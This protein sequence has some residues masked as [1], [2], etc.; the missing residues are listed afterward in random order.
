[1]SISLCMINPSANGWIEKFFKD[2]SGSFY[3]P[4]DTLGL[5][6]AIRKTGFLYG[7]PKTIATV[8]VFDKVGLS[9]DEVSKIAFLNTLYVTFKLV[10][11]S[12]SKDT[13]V[14]EAIAYYKL[15]TKQNKWSLDFLNIKG[16]ASNQLEEIINSR[17]QI[18]S[19]FFNKTYTFLFNNALLFIDILG[20]YTYLCKGEISI[21]YLKKL[22][23][24]CMAL[25]ML[26]VKNKEN[27]KDYEVVLLKMIESSLRYSKFNKKSEFTIETLDFSFFENDIERYYFYDLI[28]MALWKEDATLGDRE[29]YFLEDVK[30][31]LNLPASF[32]NI[33]SGNVNDFIQENKSDLSIFNYSNPLIQFYENSNKTVSKLIKRNGKRLTKEIKQSKE[34]MLLL[35][36]STTK[37]LNKEEKKKVK[38]QLLDI[39]KSVPSLAIF[40]LP[41]GS[42]LLPILIKYIPK[43]LPSAFNENLED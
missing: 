22:E 6:I 21:E 7:H 35:A 9:E 28:L 42:L 36:K 8:L 18:N 26:S 12:N 14:A 3:S 32:Y 23:Y 17:V 40:L 43:L 10:K 39:C 20:F 25:V 4:K 19:N 11:K 27:I 33:N 15:I 31:I 16:S 24:N 41:G 2:F 13:F 38:K 29:K 30:T 37:D 5:Y 1:M 34:L